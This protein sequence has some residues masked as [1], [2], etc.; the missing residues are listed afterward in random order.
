[1]IRC[2]VGLGNPGAQYAATRHNIGFRVVNT[3]ALAHNASWRKGWWRA[4]WHA[5]IHAPDLLLCKPATY[6]NRSGNAVAEL[7][8]KYGLDAQEL[9]VVYD[10]VHLPLGRLRARRSGSAGGHNGMHSVI[11]CLG[12]EDVPRLRV[13][14]GASGADRVAHVLS[15]FEPDEQPS[16]DA[17]VQA[18]AQAAVLLAT[19][20]WE[21]AQQRINAWRPGAALVAPHDTTTVNSHL[22]TLTA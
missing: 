13:G 9:L 3:L 20:P 15:A 12:T 17:A 2:V 1:V 6:M 19:M 4:Y 10:D 16:A 7:C 11:T 8:R 21:L 18:G 14:I 5:Q 22:T